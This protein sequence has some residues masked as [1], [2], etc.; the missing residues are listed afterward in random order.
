MV[1]SLYEG[2]F[3]KLACFSLGWPA[4]LKFLSQVDAS[5]PNNIDSTNVRQN[6]SILFAFDEEDGTFALLTTCFL[7]LQFLTDV[8]VIYQ[9]NYELREMSLRSYNTRCTF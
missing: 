9:L 4:R 5:T 1:F 3:L 6:V 8:D 7:L 2:K